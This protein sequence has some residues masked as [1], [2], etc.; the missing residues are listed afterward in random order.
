MI[1]Y[2]ALALTHALIVIALIRLLSRP[3]LDSE[4]LLAREEEEVAE[5]EMSPREKRRARARAEARD[6]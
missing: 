4:D 1:D 6:A 3:E 5:A 2:F